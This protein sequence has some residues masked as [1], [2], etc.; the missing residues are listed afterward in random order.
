[1]KGFFVSGTDTDVGKT[2]IS[3]GLAAVLREKNVEV[4][5]FKPMLS[6]ISR[7]D[8]ESDTAFLKEMSQ[9]PL[10]AEEITPF[11]FREPVSPLVAAQQEGIK[12]ELEEVVQKWEKIRGQ[13]D[14]FIVEGAGGI[15]VPLGEKFLVSDVIQKT[16]LP[17]IIVARPDLGT[18]NHTFL[19]VQYARSAGIKVAGIIINGRT[20]KPDL[21]EKTNP[22]VIEQLTGVPVLGVTPRLKKVTKRNVK[23]MVEECIDVDFL[24]KQMEGSYV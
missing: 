4:G 3:G 18:I 17:L 13:C 24:M 9:T 22:A 19:T 16:G 15:S 10:T 7:E 21:A 14:C 12:V 20:E 23:E 2:I 6:G 1:M 11:A 5:V 8:P